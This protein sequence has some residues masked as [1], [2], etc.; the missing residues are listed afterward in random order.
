M[1]VH[2]MTKEALEDVVARIFEQIDA[3]GNGVLDKDEF[4]EAL[5]MMELGLTRKEINAIMY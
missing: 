3:D 5:Q 1:L 2:G 4:V